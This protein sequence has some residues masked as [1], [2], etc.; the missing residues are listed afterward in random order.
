MNIFIDGG[1]K[2]DP[3]LVVNVFAYQVDSTRRIGIG[4]RVAIEYF[5][6]SGDAIFFCYG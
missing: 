5:F 4:F 6:E 2:Y 1:R 3:V